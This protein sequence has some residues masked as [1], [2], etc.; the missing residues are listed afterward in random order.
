MKVVEIFSSIDGEGI[1]AG[2]P[3]T[4]VR[5]Y[6]C[7]LNCSYCDTPYSHLI[8][9]DKALE[10]SIDEIVN[11]VEHNGIPSVTIT[12]GEPMIHK[13]IVELFDELIK[14]GYYVNVETNGTCQVPAK[15]DYT[16][17]DRIIFTMDYK[18]PSSGMCEEMSIANLNTLRHNDVLKFVVGSVHDMD[19][20]RKVLG[21]IDS[22][23]TVY[24]SPVFGQIAPD[25]IVKYLL[26]H[27]LYDCRVQIQM[28]KVI[29]NPNERGV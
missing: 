14:R 29:W 5:L 17:S 11:T 13:D 1:R 15:Y 7:N 10:M 6:G 8:E 12:G 18:C 23:P 4:F 21:M 20:A 3:V 24:F 22:C 2:L 16:N 25:N 28:H 27:H 19:E 26:E 9:E